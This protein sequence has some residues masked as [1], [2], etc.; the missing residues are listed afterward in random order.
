MATT[1]LCSFI[2]TGHWLT[3]D[4]VEA[5]EEARITQHVQ[6]NCYILGLRNCGNAPLLEGERGRPPAQAAVS[7]RLSKR[8]VS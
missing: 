7:A 1:A 5:N 2:P 4:G 8:F 6:E 3:N